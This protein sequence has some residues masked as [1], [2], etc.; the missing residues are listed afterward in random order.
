MVIPIQMMRDVN[1][2]AAGPPLEAS[3]YKAGWRVRVSRALSNAKIAAMIHSMPCI[4][5]I[6]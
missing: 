2:Q 4:L 6:L 3:T 1:I 5:V